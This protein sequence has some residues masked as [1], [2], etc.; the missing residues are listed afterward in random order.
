MHRKLTIFTNLND[1]KKYSNLKHLLSDPTIKK[2]ISDRNIKIT[3]ERSVDDHLKLYGYDNELKYHTK[4][5]TQNEFIKIFQLIDEM[6]I[7]KR[8]L[9][10]KNLKGGD[11]NLYTDNK[12]HTT[13]KNTGFKDKKTA[14]KTLK[15]IEKRSIV[16]QKTLVNTMYY[17]AKHH[18]NKTRDMNEA[19]TIFQKW[20]TLNKNKKIKYD[21]LDLDIVKKYE[22]LA[23]YYDVSRVTRGL[24]KASKS[25]QG[26][27]VVYKKNKGNKNKLSFIPIFKNKPEGQ[28]Y[29]IFREK[30]I[31][32]RLGQMKK[33]KT[34]LYTKDG[35]PT[36]QHVIL[37][38][39]AYSPDPTGLKKKLKLLNNL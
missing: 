24:E 21:Y 25:D 22:K 10:A 17:R 1:A 29:D 14:I 38:M 3:I 36:K 31:N 2:E 23:N 7:R 5:I 37:I 15:L 9:D 16:Y 19:I 11:M 35:L 27:L 4:Y 32:S 12:P 6:P 20:L 13:L 8:E 18:P 30:F 28:D 33:A 39:H 34:K 26:F